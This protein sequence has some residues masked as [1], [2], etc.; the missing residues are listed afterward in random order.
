[1]SIASSGENAFSLLAQNPKHVYAIDLSQEQIMCCMLKVAAYKYLDYQ[2]CMELIGVF[3]SNRRQELYKK[4]SY[5]LSEQ[6]LEY[7]Y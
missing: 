6:V 5:Y 1:M 7:Y 3:E 2:E 4:I